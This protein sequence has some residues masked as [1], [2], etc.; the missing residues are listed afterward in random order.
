TGVAA[1]VRRIEGL[2]GLNVYSYIKDLEQ[3]LDETSAELKINIENIPER[4]RILI[5]D[6][7]KSN[8]EIELLRK[9]IALKTIDDI[10]ANKQIIDEIP[11]IAVSVENQDMD[12]LRSM[13]DLLK[14]KMKTGL[15]VLASG[16]NNKV[17]LVAGA[18]KD[19]V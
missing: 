1:G 4:V 7:K 5:D 16:Y 11:Y 19:V 8:R 14:D 18:T 3:M 6:L 2:T 17:N 12:S 15:V 10:I 13:A 9:D